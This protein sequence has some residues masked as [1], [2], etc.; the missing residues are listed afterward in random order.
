MIEAINGKDASKYSYFSNENEVILG[1][2]TELQVKGNKLKHHGGLNIVHLVELND[3][4]DDVNELPQA[5]GKMDI[6][7]K[8]SD[9]G[10]T[11]K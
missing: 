8:I 1:L 9:K 2:G 7:P 5:I 6:Q 10:A 3:N 11:G 4:D